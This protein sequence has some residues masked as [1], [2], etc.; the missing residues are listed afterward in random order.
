MDARLES[1]FRKMLPEVP[2]TDQCV[3]WPGRLDRYGYGRIGK[4]GLAHRVSYE[5]HRAAPPRE[6]CVCHTCDNPSCVNPNHLWLG[7][8]KDNALDK[9]RKGRAR[10]GT[11][12]R[13]GNHKLTAA[14]AREIFLAE[15][16]QI[17]IARRFRIAQSTVSVIKRGA[18]WR[19]ET[20]HLKVS[21]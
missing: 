11:G 7:T 8:P 17:S 5:L 19:R 14:T 20:S 16:T 21:P 18:V 6:M 10:G 9:S 3:R 1:N 15:G 2:N 4:A 13:N 12:E